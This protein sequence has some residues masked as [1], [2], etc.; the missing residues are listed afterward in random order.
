M[1]VIKSATY[2]TRCPFSKKLIYPQNKICLFSFEQFVAFKK[3]VSDEFI[4]RIRTD[5]ITLIIEK[6]G[7]DTVIF[8]DTIKKKFFLYGE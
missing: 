2:R 8:G 7:Y 5:L 4:D 1:V 3:A 6:T